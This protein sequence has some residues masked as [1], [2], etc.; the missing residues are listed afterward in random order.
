MIKVTYLPEFEKS[1][2]PNEDTVHNFIDHR[3][4]KEWVLGYVCGSCLLGFETATGRSADTLED[5]LSQGCGCE[6]EIEDPD[7]LGYSMTRY[8]LYSALG[9]RIRKNL[10]SG[11]YEM[12]PI[13]TDNV[14]FRGSLGEMVIEANRREGQEN[15]TIKCNGTCPKLQS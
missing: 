8:N 6:I 10:K 7:N 14:V 9:L 3:A 5:W 1:P 13:G 4:F 12:F 2:L 11:L 15:T